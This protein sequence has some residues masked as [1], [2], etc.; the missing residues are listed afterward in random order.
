MGSS[1]VVLGGYFNLL[2]GVL[3]LGYWY[4][5]A[6]FLPYGQLSSTLSILVRNRNWLWINALGIFGALAGLLGQASILAFQTP[7]AG[8]YSS[9]G[10]LV[11]V[12]GTTLLIGTMSWET[13][14]WPLLQKHDPSLMEFGGPIYSSRIFLG[15]FVVSGLVF[16]LGYLLVGLGIALTSV[17][18]P[19]AG[20]LVAIGAPTFGLGALFGRYQVYVRSAG[21]TLMSSGLIW[22]ALAMV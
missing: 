9:I 15:F 16:S 20:L 2:A 19:T 3:L 17:L 10:F 5:Y 6:L 13:V 11:A 1:F 18:P 4:S 7:S 14:L 22:L 8:W 12:A 21:V